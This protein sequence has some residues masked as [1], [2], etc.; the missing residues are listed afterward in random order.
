MALFSRAAEKAVKQA[1]GEAFDESAKRLEE[2]RR[3]QFMLVGEVARLQLE[4]TRAHRANDL[5]NFAL[6][7]VADAENML[8][9]GEIVIS[10]Y[11]E[12]EE[13][14]RRQVQLLEEAYVTN[15]LFGEAKQNAIDSITP[16]ER[17]AMREKIDA[18]L[19]QNGTY[20]VIQKSV[21]DEIYEQELAAAMDDVQPEPDKEPVT[22]QQKGKTLEQAQLEAE[23][24]SEFILD[25]RERRILVLVEVIHAYVQELASIRHLVKGVSGTSIYRG[26]KELLRNLADV[27]DELI[28]AGSVYK[29]E[30]NEPGGVKPL[31]EKYNL[32][33]SRLESTEG[34]DKIYLERSLYIRQ[35]VSAEQKLKLLEDRQAQLYKVAPKYRNNKSGNE[36]AAVFSGQHRVVKDMI[37]YQE[38]HV[39]ELYNWIRECD[40]QIQDYENEEPIVIDQ[41][42]DNVEAQADTKFELNLTKEEKR[43]IGQTNFIDEPTIGVLA[44]VEINDRISN[45]K[46]EH[47][48]LERLHMEFAEINQTLARYAWLL[49]STAN[50]RGSKSERKAAVEEVNRLVE[51]KGDVYRQIVA[52]TPKGKGVPK[53]ISRFPVLALQSR[54]G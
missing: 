47:S 42:S 46:L 12:A 14:I 5:A 39:Q 33:E 29:L 22:Q 34:L 38:S 15:D 28:Y 50:V 45:H 52:I 20:D 11:V 8:R 53:N 31:T 37:A 9:N 17:Q 48:E 10:P 19:K 21:K 49:A 43:D 24:E 54:L 41:A 2:A 4:L 6:R 16:D 27:E 13:I 18:D 30:L 51:R 36:I 1:D 23:A 32:M 25:Q 35:Q 3:A 7:A 40:K 26:K 44:E